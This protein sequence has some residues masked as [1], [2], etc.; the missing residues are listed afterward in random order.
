MLTFSAP[1]GVSTGSAI[2]FGGGGVGVTNSDVAYF[3]SLRVV[4]DDSLP[5]VGTTGENQ[6]FVCYLFG[7]GAVKTGSQFGMQIETERNILSRQNIMTVTYNSCMHIPG[8]SYAGATTDPENSDLANSANW[9]FVYDD[10][11]T[12]P[13]VALTVSSPYGGVIA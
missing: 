1:A 11:R 5:I 13:V 8:I 12:V 10:L 9:S 7:S 2:Q 6:Q 4:I 3:A